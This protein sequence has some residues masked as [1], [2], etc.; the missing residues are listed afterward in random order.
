MKYIKPKSLTWW[1]GGFSLAVGL[2]T[3]F[4]PDN[5]QVGQ[6]GA[7]VS[8]LAGGADA[9]PAGLIAMGLGLI[10]LREAIEH[11]FRGAPV[12]QGGDDA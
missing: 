11:G 8:I 3:L 7:L 12:D 9:S 6:I 1:A 4:M 2:A 5:Y 10:G